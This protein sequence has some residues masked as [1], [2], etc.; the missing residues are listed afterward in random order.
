MKKPKQFADFWRR[1][2]RNKTSVVAFFI[3][4]I[5]LFFAIFADAFASYEFDVLQPDVSALMKPPSSE[6]IFGTDMMGRDM[7][8]RIIHGARY[9]L[10]IGLVSSFAIIIFGSIVGSA[11]AFFGGWIDNAIMRVCDVFMC[12]PGTLMTMTL[13]IILGSGI[14]SLILALVISGIPGCAIY[15]RALV[16]NI[17][18]QDY[19]ES[20][21]ASGVRTLRILL[22]HVVPNAM[23]PIIVSMTMNISGLIMTGSGL[24]FIGIG[25]KP[26]IPEWGTMVSEGRQFMRNAPHLILVPGI[27]I[28]LAALAFNL[29]GDGLADAL[30]PRM[31]D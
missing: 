27:A 6:H 15:I 9:S 7:F 1:F 2:S 26:P 30:D 17:V 12:V 21:K 20:A 10:S 18:R 22:F 8:A 25:V 29:L 4:A 14:R 13:V 31:K 19:I 5:M 16:L 23:G 24:S 11:A 28:G 3:I